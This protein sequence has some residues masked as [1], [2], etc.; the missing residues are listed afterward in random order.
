MQRNTHSLGFMSL[1]IT[2][3]NSYASYDQRKMHFVVFV[4]LVDMKLA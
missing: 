4:I 3:G 2:T 1:W